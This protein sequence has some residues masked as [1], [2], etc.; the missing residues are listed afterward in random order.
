MCLNVS[1]EVEGTNASEQYLYKPQRGMEYYLLFLLHVHWSIT[2]RLVETLYEIS[3]KRKPNKTVYSN[4]V[5]KGSGEKVQQSALFKWGTER[6]KG[7]YPY[8]YTDVCL[9]TISV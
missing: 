7:Q 9:Q 2:G 8:K 6:N 3:N 1:G 5:Y 4:Q